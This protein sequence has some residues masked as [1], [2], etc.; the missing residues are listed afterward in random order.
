MSALSDHVVLVLLTVIE[1]SRKTLTELDSCYDSETK[2]SK[3]LKVSKMVSTK[4]NG[5]K[6][7]MFVLFNRSAELIEKLREMALPFDT[8]LAIFLLVASM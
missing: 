4:Y 1:N 2:P 5:L 6:E 3:I 7:I 8:S